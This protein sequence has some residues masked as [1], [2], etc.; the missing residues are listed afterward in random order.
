[1]KVKPLLPSQGNPLFS[2]RAEGSS[3]TEQFKPAPTG[4]EPSKRFRQPDQ[5]AGKTHIHLKK[6]AGI[7]HPKTRERRTS[8]P[9]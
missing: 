3:A 9:R 7:A 8:R 4:L 6:L 1:M 2:A 5:S